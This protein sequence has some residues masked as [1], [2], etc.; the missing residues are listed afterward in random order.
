MAAQNSIVKYFDNFKGL[1]LRVSDLKRQQGASTEEK[2]VTRRR[3]GAVSKRKGYQIACRTSGGNGLFNYL[4]RETGSTT[5]IAEELLSVD[6]DMNRLLT[7]EEFNITYTGSTGGY[8]DMYLNETNNKFY[9]D[10]YDDNVRVLNQDLG[11]G[12][13]TS[14]TTIATLVT[15]VNGL[16]NFTCSSGSSYTTEPAAFIPSKLNITIP[17]TPGLDIAF[18][19][20]ETVPSPNGVS[21]VLSGHNGKKDD[22]DFRNMSATSIDEAL[23]IAG[24]GIPLHKYDG[25]RC[26]AAGLAQ[27][28]APTLSATLGGALTG[29]YKWKITY[30]YYDAKGNIIESKISPAYNNTLSSN[31]IT[32][33][34]PNMQ[35][36]TGYNTDQA[37]VS[38]AGTS[39]TIPVTNPHYVQALDTVAILDNSTGLVTREKVLST[40]STTL[41]LENSIQ[42]AT[43]DIASN[44]AIKLWRTKA[45]GSLY[46]FVTELANDTGNAT[47]NYTD[48]KA[49]SA[50]GTEFI[51]PVKDH[52]VPPSNCKYSTVWRGQLILAGNEESPN[53]IYYSDIESGEYFPSVD[54][55]FDIETRSGKEVTGVKALDNVLYIFTEDAIIA[56]TGDLATDSFVV[57]TFSD[58]GIGCRAH[59]TIQEIDNEI[60]FLSTSGIYGVSTK[61]LSEKSAQIG[62]EFKQGNG[63][64]YNRAT[65]F[66]WIDQ[67]QYLLMLP[68]S[69]DNGSGAYY[70]V[71][72]TSKTYVF[73]RFWKSWTSWTNYDFTGG[74]A[75]LGDEIYMVDRSIDAVTSAVRSYAKKVYSNGLTNDYA[76]H[77]DPIEFSYKSHWETLGEP[78]MFKKYRRIK[79]FSLDASLDDFESESFE[80]IMGVQNDYID[81]N[82]SD[83]TFDF[84]G[85]AAGWGSP[86][87]GEFSW[88][89]VRLFT[90][91]HKLNQKRSKAARV[92]F[93]NNKV[94]ENVLVSGYELDIVT[95]YKPEI[96]E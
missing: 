49:D 53:T 61:G 89:E 48:N 57:D 27:P 15:A 1:D 91:K 38:G 46:Y 42:Y 88:G 60:W 81:F 72:A 24:D 68:V 74:M 77:E 16:T 63:F 2:N 95:P 71:A 47:Q 4:N 90:L 8:Y 18:S 55:S 37:T 79:I 44:V 6:D 36:T 94:N 92:T 9:F 45:G 87:W 39:A 12:R 30:E 51:D 34:L 66:H 25:N 50:L 75:M 73:D 67:R 86:A 23:Y 14:F 28:T 19:A 65:A 96:K 59:N 17:T 69:Q 43:N 35:N 54:N 10:V 83:H 93:T 56:V 64:D 3:T 31:S 5:T 32:L 82:V 13:E 41:V 62:P 7:A 52:D 85:G 70:S 80:I 26:Y 22:A 58:E 29:A 40:T 76:D 21:T 20:W 84:G 11:T 33:T 78:S